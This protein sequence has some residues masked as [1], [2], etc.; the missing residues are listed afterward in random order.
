MEHATSNAAGLHLIESR[1][2]KRAYCLTPN[3]ICKVNMHYEAPLLCAL[4]VPRARARARI[5][6]RRPR[7][8]RCAVEPHVCGDAAGDAASRSRPSSQLV[9]QTPSRSRHCGR[10]PLQSRHVAVLSPRLSVASQSPWS[11]LPS[12]H[13]SQPPSQLPSQPAVAIAVAI[14]VAIAVAMSQPPWIADPFHCERC[15]MCTGTELAHF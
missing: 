7:A 4:F 10:S 13:R 9:S 3:P 1:I 6:P 15:R 12:S 11:Q 14:V 2:H 8:Q 5:L